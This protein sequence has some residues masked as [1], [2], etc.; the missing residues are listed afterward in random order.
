M[1]GVAI[2]TG[3]AGSIGMATCRQLVSD[4]F[5][6]VIADT[7][8]P[9]EPVEGCIFAELDVRSASNIDALFD[10]AAS[11]GPI[12]AVVTAHGILRGTPVGA[13]DDDAVLST[14][15]INLTGVARLANVAA[16]RVA[17]G[18]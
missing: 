8:P 10:V 13:F 14:F 12:A 15:D 17:D 1:A 2:V 6:V 5:T 7:R 16:K 18:G 3:G 11:H 4:G 9:A